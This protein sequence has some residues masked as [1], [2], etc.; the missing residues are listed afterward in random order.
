[1]V[2][3]GER[4]YLEVVMVLPISIDKHSGIPIYV[5][6]G[7][8]IR[9]LIREGTLG[10]GDAMPTV[11]AL[12][13]QLGINA[14]TVARVYRELQGAGVLRLERGIGTFVSE[15]GER[16][17]EKKELKQLEKKAFDVIRIARQVGMSSGELS[18]LIETR[19]QEVS[20]ATRQ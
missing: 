16:R 1:L 2:G 4:A 6:L 3:E 15:G 14:N 12:A 5:Q 8:R 13:V 11:R 9:L 18:Q 20:D 19:W 10:P 7:E 17:V